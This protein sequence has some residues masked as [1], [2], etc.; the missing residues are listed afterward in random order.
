MIRHILLTLVLALLPF[1][2]F[3]QSGPFLDVT[4]PEDEEF[5]VGQPINL[6]MKLLVPTWML[7]PPRW[8]ELEVPS[9]T[10]S[11]SEAI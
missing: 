2:T 4:L 8:P 9:F 10:A 5:L 11:S 6:Q 7:E 3:A 1:S